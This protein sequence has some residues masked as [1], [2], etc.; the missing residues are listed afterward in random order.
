V[1]I[2]IIIPTYN[3]AP[4]IAHTIH[5]L[6]QNSNG[7]I[8]EIIVADGSSTDGTAAIAESA[9]AKVLHCT[10][11]SRAAQ[12]NQGAKAAISNVLYFVHADTLPPVTY[13]EDIQNSI[14][15]GHTMGCFRYRFDS[16]NLML[17]INS[18][19]TRFNWL[20]C[21]GGDKTFF[22]ERTT[23]EA[24]NGYDEHHIIMEEYDF[25]QRA[26]R[27]GYRYV[28]LPSEVLVSARKYEHNSWL[29]VQLA[30]L[31]VFNFWRTGRVEPVRLKRIYQRLL[32]YKK[33]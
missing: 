18:W 3:E 31:I 13:A 14:E 15:A 21:Q 1:K 20:F 28:V 7:A 30:N 5:Y 29:R 4:H 12:L 11:R 9:G 2:S 25:L 19:F 8:A 6:T 27:H 22:I 16:D 17:R 33:Y 23:F 26:V 24:L 32:R 10:V